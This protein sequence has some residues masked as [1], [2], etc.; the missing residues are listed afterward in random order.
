M[1]FCSIDWSINSIVNFENKIIRDGRKVRK[2]LF[3]TIDICAG[4]LIEAEG[5][6][7]KFKYSDRLDNVSQIFLLN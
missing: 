3:F 4:K 2:N 7:G 6:R 5:S 1:R